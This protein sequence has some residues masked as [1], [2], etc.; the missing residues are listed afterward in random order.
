LRGKKPHFF[1]MVFPNLQFAFQTDLLFLHD[2]GA[3]DN[4]RNKFLDNLPQNLDAVGRNR[5]VLDI[6]EGIA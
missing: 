6:L 5:N 1:G 4:G 3:L 2:D